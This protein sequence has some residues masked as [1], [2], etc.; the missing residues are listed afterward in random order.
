VAQRV[1]VVR[2]AILAV[3]VAATLGA[4]HLRQRVHAISW[5][6][7]DA[8]PIEACV[9]IRRPIEDVFVFYRDFRNL[10]RFLGDVTLV[11][12]LDRVTYR[13]TILGPLGIRLTW[14]VRVTEQQT[15]ARIRYETVTSPALR[16]EW[17]VRFRQGIAADQTEVREVMKTPLG[18]VGR[19]SLA[20]IGKDPSAEVSSNL[21]RLK[22]V[23]ETGWVR[24]TSNAVAGKF[25]RVGDHS[26]SKN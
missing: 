10:P 18:R 7:R 11:E 19:M 25:R 12:P 23:M 14:K 22:E 2:V 6:W 20:L 21:Q 16:T 5:L 24:D 4:I 9:T 8:G 1:V 3:T 13:W 15:D 26:E 17:E